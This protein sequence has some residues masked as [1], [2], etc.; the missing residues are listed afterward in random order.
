M[1]TQNYLIIENNI[2][3]NIV[4]WDGNLNTW[5]PPVNSIQIV[6]E[7]VTTKLWDSFSQTIDGKTVIDWQLVEKPVVAEVGYTWDGQY[8]ITNEPKP[9]VIPQI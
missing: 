4:M 2:V 6:K 5:T 3:T 9:A 1:T 8:L 7:T